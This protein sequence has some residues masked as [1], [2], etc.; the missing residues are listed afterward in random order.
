MCLL[1]QNPNLGLDPYQP[2]D[3]GSD[4]IIEGAIT[5]LDV[6]DNNTDFVAVSNTI[7]TLKIASSVLTL[8]LR[9]AESITGITGA[10]FDIETLYAIAKTTAQQN[11]C[12]F[13]I[14]NSPQGGTLFINNLDPYAAAVK[15]TAIANG[16]SVYNL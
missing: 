13:I 15:A 4:I 6:Y 5:Q 3:A 14:N 1:I 8:D 11:V 10:P 2:L 16:W 12:E 7:D 9:N